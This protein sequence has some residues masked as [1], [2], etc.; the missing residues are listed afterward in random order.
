MTKKPIISMP[1]DKIQIPKEH[2]I[3][4]LKWVS[5]HC[6]SRTT[7]RD[8]RYRPYWQLKATAVLYTDEELYDY[9]ET[10]TK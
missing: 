8:N 7:S 5:T 1:K 4:Y 2:A 10:I 3:K 6:V 9:W